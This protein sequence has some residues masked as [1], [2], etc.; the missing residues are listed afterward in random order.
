M[1]SLFIFLFRHF[2]P[3]LDFAKVEKQTESIDPETKAKYDSG[4]CNKCGAVTITGRERL[5]SL[6]IG[7]STVYFCGNCTRFIQ[8]N[9]FNS[10][11][12]GITASLFSSLCL[13]VLV[14]NTRGESSSATSMALLV[15]LVGIYEGIKGA[16]VGVKGIKR[17]ITKR[18][19]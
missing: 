4:I 1:R 5:L 19:Q 10:I 18:A 9:P 8:G 16:F 12:L 2:E 17:S 13:V 3:R 11:F 14:S 6:F 15:L 7:K